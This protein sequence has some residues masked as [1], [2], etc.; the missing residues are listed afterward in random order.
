MHGREGRFV[1]HTVESRRPEP[2]TPVGFGTVLWFGALLRSGAIVGNAQVSIELPVPG[3]CSGRTQCGSVAGGIFEQKKSG[4]I[5]TGYAAHRGPLLITSAGLKARLLEL[6][7]FDISRREARGFR[8][9]GC[10]CFG[11][12]LWTAIKRNVSY[13]RHIGHL[14]A[15]KFFSME[16]AVPISTQTCHL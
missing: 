2:V 8:P 6:Q 5:S 15:Y 14:S 13:G 1:Q 12:S 3:G 9:V 16:L 7:P 11:A 4:A 10:S